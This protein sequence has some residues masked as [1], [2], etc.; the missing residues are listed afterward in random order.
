MDQLRKSIK[1]HEG[2]RLELYRCPA[3]KLTIGYGHNIEDNGITPEMAEFILDCDIDQAVSDAVTWLGDPGAW[4]AMNEERQAVI[5]EMLFN[6]GLTRMR[7]FKK[8]RKA[9]VLERFN[10]AAFEMVHSLW[11]R[12]VG[13]RALALARQMKTG[14]FVETP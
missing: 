9:V 3:G 6:M 10:V 7:T 5:I 8:M 11:F 1:K 14:Q 2:L 12:R 13:A 4:Q